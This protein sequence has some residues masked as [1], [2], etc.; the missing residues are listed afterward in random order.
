MTDMPLSHIR[1]KDLE[2]EKLGTHGLKRKVLHQNAT[3]GYVTSLVEIPK[4]WRGGGVAHYH[5]AFEEVYMWAGSVT[6]DGRHY[7][8]AGDYFYR[9]AFVV[10]G[11]DE[12][13]EEGA[14][15]IIRSDGPCELLLVHDPAEEDEYALKPITDQR[16]HVFSVTVADQDWQ[17]A[18]GFPEGWQIKPLSTDP[19]SGARTLAVRIPEGW[20]R[21]A[22][23][24]EGRDTDWEAMVTEGSVSSRDDTFDVGDYATGPAHV[25]AFDAD[26]SEQGCTFIL[27]QMPRNP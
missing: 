11:H 25:E 10:H 6:V 23:D 24:L 21:D 15:A 27:W 22:K 1:T 19:T 12:K 14:H 4:G 5:E 26:H 18:E 13:S 17:N 7:W 9:P 3:T 20:S 16:G 2:W 8:R